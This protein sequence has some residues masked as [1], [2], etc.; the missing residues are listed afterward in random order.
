[1]RQPDQYRPAANRRRFEAQIPGNAF[2]HQLI[3]DFGTRGAQEHS[4]LFQRFLDVPIVS[5]D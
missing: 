5:Y 1:L 4:E 2:D 3:C